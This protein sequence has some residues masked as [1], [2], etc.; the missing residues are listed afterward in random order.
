[1]KQV[2]I[3][4]LV[5]L[6]FLGL[7]SFILAADY[8]AKWVSQDQG[9]WGELNAHV[10][11][12]NGQKTVKARFEN[13]GEK[14]WSNNKEDDGYVGFYVYKDPFYS[15]LEYNDVDHPLFGSSLWAGSEWGSSYHGDTENAQAAALKENK[16][17]AGEIGTFEFTING[18]N[19]FAYANDYTDDVTTKIDER[20]HREDLSLAFRDQ[21][22][23]NTQNGDPFQVAHIWF[24][25]RFEDEELKQEELD[26]YEAIEEIIFK[27][28]A[29]A[30]D[31]LDSITE[32]ETEEEISAVI[33]ASQSVIDTIK[34]TLVEYS[35]VELPFEIAQYKDINILGLQKTQLLLDKNNRLFE[36]ILDG[37]TQDALDQMA[38]DIETLADSTSDIDQDALDFITSLESDWP[39]LDFSFFK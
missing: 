32:F 4:I 30:I 23:S 28:L 37:A 34:K 9:T 7:P 25:I 8:E 39:Q 16:V 24:P 5:C 35:S 18:P 14:C 1:M 19:L 13:V 36:A 22:M 12:M 31:A 10:V 11:F 6:G 33:D 17:C 3:R 26:D 20:I 15:P 2:L 29:K 21:W 38:E 27:D